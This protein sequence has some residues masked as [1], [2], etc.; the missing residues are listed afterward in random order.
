MMAII[1]FTLNFF[2]AVLKYEIVF[3]LFGT[4][5]EIVFMMAIINFTFYFFYQLSLLLAFEGLN[6]GFL[7]LIAMPICYQEA[8]IA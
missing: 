6:F 7:C 3:G 5:I 1:N 8:I 2:V 4:K